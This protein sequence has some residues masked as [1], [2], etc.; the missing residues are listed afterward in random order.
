MNDDI[1]RKLT[2][3]SV[4]ADLRAK[5]ARAVA[6]HA[7][8]RSLQAGEILLEQGEVA[9]HVYLVVD[10][11]LRAVLDH[12]TDAARE[13]APLEAGAVVGE[14]APL[15]G[16]RREATVVADTPT[17]V[18][19]ITARGFEQLLAD[20]PAV[21]GRLAAL[22]TE[23]L[24]EAQLARQVVQLFPGV[25]SAV[26]DQ[27]TTDAD[28]VSL[29]AGELLM[30][31]GDPA[32]AAYVIVSGRLR[33]VTDDQ[34][35]PLPAEVGPGELVGETALIEDGI[36]TATLVAIRDTHAVRLRRERL[37]TALR[38]HP[39]ALLRIMRIVLR[40]TGRADQAQGGERR[41]VAL[42]AMHPSVDLTGL[43]DALATSLRLMGTTGLL[44]SQDADAIASTAGSR[45]TAADASGVA[46]VTRWL[47]EEEQRYDTL[48]LQMDAEPSAWNEIVLRHADHLMTIADARAG[49][50]PTAVEQR[51]LELLRT[52]TGSC[53]RSVLPRTSLVLIHPRA[54]LLRE[55]PRGTARWLALRT[56]DAWYHLRREHP[57]DIARLARIVAER[58]IGLVLSGGGARGF[59]HLGVLRALEEAEV[60]VDILVGSSIGA[61]MA[62]FFALGH[63]AE[64]CVRQAKTTLQG[65]M[66]WTLPVASLASG[67]RMSERAHR[68]VDDRDIED[69]WLPW[70]AVTTNLTRR[71]VQLHRRGPLLKALRA[72]VAIPGVVPPVVYG[73]DLH[74]DGGV[75]DNL[76]LEHMR[77]VDPRGPVIAVDVAVSSGPQ[78]TED[79]G[80]ALSGWKLLAGRVL[81]GSSPE[82]PGIATML[83]SS[84]LAGSSRERDRVVADGLA[85]LYLG[86]D[87][88]TCGLLEFE[89]ADRLVEAGYEA[90]LPQIRK[91]CQ[92]SIAAGAPTLDG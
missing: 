43:A 47:E 53:D 50:V 62:A 11:R 80:L 5:S 35:D 67:T 8:Q 36:R 59:A 57:P 70:L 81:P 20:E 89:A 6:E 12:G 28:W 16:G 42:A 55:A 34:D 2:A 90:A 40:R 37:L 63:D 18:L 71:E 21:A 29:Q 4:F 74:I 79:F 92:H 44:S 22:A 68:V 82:V 39:D 78:A 30:D 14:I 91:W 48:L 61:V 27:L 86:L 85:D 76:P 45:P 3:P 75:L 72:T 84:M 7:H 41:S 38:G 87:L 46:L 32:D 52:R 77:Q 49:P 73:E 56:V 10:G 19:E 69:L 83:T 23:R 9:D 65:I 13:L 88:P 15:T 1:T 24:H 54:E 58:P 31:R 26:H 25:D 33:V 60:P 17:T 51:I 66:D 64:E